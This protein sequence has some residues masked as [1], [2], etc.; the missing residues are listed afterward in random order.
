MTA[1]SRDVVVPR[2]RLLLQR[3]ASGQGS[4][5]HTIWE[6]CDP[7]TNE[8]QGLLIYRAHGYPTPVV[9]W[10]DERQSGVVVSTFLYRKS[11]NELVNDPTEATSENLERLRPKLE[12]ALRH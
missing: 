3:L 4:S 11:A 9:V 12:E 5:V 8:V 1:L 6:Q 10:F 2:I 7:N